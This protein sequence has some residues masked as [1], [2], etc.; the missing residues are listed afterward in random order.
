MILNVLIS[1]I[2]NR[3]LGLKNI[4]KEKK[5]V[6]Y[7]VS[8]Q[9][10]SELDEQTQNYKETLL[11]LSNVVYSQ[12]NSRGV[13]KNRN[14]ALKYRVKD[15]I[16]LLCDDDV[17]YFEKSFDTIV[18]T[19]LKDESLEFLTFKIKTFQG[20]DYKNYRDYEFR[21]NI[22]TLTS[23]GIIDVAFKEEVIEKYSLSF[24]ER[25]GPGAKYAIGEDFIFMTDACK[26]GANIVYKPIDIVQHDTL[27][28]GATLRDD[29]IFGRGAMFARVFGLNAAVINMLFA[30]K[31]YVKYKTKYT[32]YNYTS[33][34][35]KGMIDYF[36]SRS[37]V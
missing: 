4:I 24:D 8:H 1:T 18:E 9:V 20:D 10:T 17:I 6:I 34:L 28:T 27:G 3:I 26:K 11:G 19:F 12:I 15:S 30:S 25:F 32:F 5:D 13:A 37:D 14:N 16:C 7:T 2:D 21:Q 33:L 23:I 31:N 29:I 35:Y 22:R 36:R